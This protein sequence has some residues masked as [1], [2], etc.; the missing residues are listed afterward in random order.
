MS[1]LRDAWEG[2]AE[3]WIAWARRPGHDSYDEWHREAFL[4]LLPAPGRRTV[5]VGCGEGRLSRTLR[6]A[7]HCVVGV[8][9]SPTL[10]A[11]ARGSDPSVPVLLADAAALPLADDVA[12]LAVAF[13]VL[14]DLDD[15][16][17]AV[18]EIARVLVPGGLLCAAVVHPI[19]SAGG[20][21][22][23]EAGSPYVIE[24][25]YFAGRRYADR[26]ERD[27]LEITF[28]SFHHPLE[29]Y[30]RALERSGFVV[31]ALREPVAP[32]AAVRDDSHRRW[33]R[34]PVFLHLRARLDRE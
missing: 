30:T 10:L 32:A 13:M 28:H 16:P 15:L 11:A 8:D 3:R 22:S 2:E 18:D 12:D 29:D 34:L 33:Q 4:P 31:E 5:D 27:G 20:F 21:V 17:G 23:R 19:N 26:I 7:G 1:D 25:S 24:G 14:H 9:G 6:A